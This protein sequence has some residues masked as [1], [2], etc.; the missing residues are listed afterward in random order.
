MTAV[1]YFQVMIKGNK[2]YIKPSAGRSEKRNTIIR[3]VNEAKIRGPV[4]EPVC[5]S[6]CPSYNASV[7]CDRMCSHAPAFLSSEP[8]TYPIDKLVAPLVFEIKKLGVF[9]PCWSCEG[10]NDTTGKLWKIPRVW[11]YSTSVVHVRALASAVT[12]LY[13]KHGLNT[14][15]VVEIVHSDNDNPD[16]TFSLHPKLEAKDLNIYQLQSDLKTIYTNIEYEFK[17]ACESL[18]NNA[19]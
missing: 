6:S 11:F 17:L 9:E 19:T 10:H 12:Q 1:I 4:A 2:L 7:G 15:W 3:E 18:K 13:A 8:E 16:T 5:T 14:T